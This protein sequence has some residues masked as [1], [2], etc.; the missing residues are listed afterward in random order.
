MNVWETRAIARLE[1][2][3]SYLYLYHKKTIVH[4]GE[5]FFVKS[6]LS[7]MPSTILHV[8]LFTTLC[9]GLGLLVNEA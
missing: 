6:F 2:T 8:A 7:S 3:H 9:S 1:I 4:G 5:L